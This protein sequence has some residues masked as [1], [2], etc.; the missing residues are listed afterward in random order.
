M[1]KVTLASRVLLGLIFVLSGVAFFFTTPPP[2]EGPM[3]LFFN[4]MMAT[5][6]FFY[7][8]KFTEITCGLALISGM[9]VPLALIVL[10][11]ILLNV[12]LVHAFM[13]PQ[14]LPLAIVMG[15]LAVYLSFGSKEYSPKIKALFRK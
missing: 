15:V 12:F 2:M 9:Y 10:A 6:Y 5:H 1:K 3:A 4:G 14:G 7:L 11:P 13:M 8:L